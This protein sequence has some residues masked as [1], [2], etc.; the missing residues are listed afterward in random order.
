MDQREHDGHVRLRRQVSRRTRHSAALTGA[1]QSARR[2]QLA[3]PLLPFSV[4]R[5]V[6]ASRRARAS[7][8]SRRCARAL[9]SRGRCTP[10]AINRRCTS[11]PPWRSA[12]P[13]RGRPR[14]PAHRAT[15][16][17]DWLDRRRRS[18]AHRLA[19][20]RDDPD[21]GQR[22]GHEAPVE[23]ADRQPAA[24]DA[25]PVSAAHRRQRRD[26]VGR[27]GDRHPR[28]RV[29]QRVW[30][31]RRDRAQIWKRKFDST[32]QEQPRRPRRR[33]AV[34][35]RPDGH[36]GARRAHAGQVRR[37]RG[38]VGRPPAHARRRDRRGDRAAATLRAAQRQALRAEPG[39]R[40]DLHVHRAGLRRQSEQLL[41]VRSRRRRRSATG[42]R[43]AAACGRA[44]VPRS[45]RTAPSTPAAATATT[46]PSSRSTA[47]R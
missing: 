26:P 35:R 22:Q 11:L 32:F 29:R 5:F 20:Q 38:L 24:A 3:L 36:A 27:Q 45:A 25:Q 23:G 47:R 30:H 9:S 15:R 19:A 8:P 34:P 16:K 1:T 42:R 39:E 37:L 17:A 40:C 46:C 44:P 14:R 33:R 41:R 4:D 13:R 10:M 28:R 18:A 43:A 12:Q 2:I 31:R 7:P 21:E 6:S